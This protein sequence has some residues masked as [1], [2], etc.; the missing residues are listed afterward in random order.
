[1]MSM[2][3]THAQ[4]N[5]TGDWHGTLDVQG[6]MTLRIVFHINETDGKLISTLDSP[7]QS[8]FGL[9]TSETD[10]NAPALTIKMPNLQ[11]EYTGTVNTDFTEMTGTFTQG[12]PMPLTMTRNAVEAKPVLRPQEPKPPFPYYTEDVTYENESA[13]ITLAGTL[14]LPSKDGKYPVVV[15]VSGSGAQ[16]RNEELLGHKPF[17]VIADYLTRHGIG[18]LRYDDRGVGGSTG[19]HSVATSEDFATDAQSAVAYLKTRSEVLPKKIGIAGHSEG[20][21]IAPMCAVRSKDVAFIVLLAGTG[22]DGEEILLTQID[23]INRAND[24]SEEKNKAELAMMGKALGMVKSENDT[25]LLRQ[26][27]NLLFD[28][29]YD[30]L[31]EEDK[32]AAGTKETF[33]K[34]Q[35]ETLTSDWFRFFI[36]YD[37]KATLEKVTCPVLAIN[38]EKDLQVEPK[39]NLGGIE[40]ALKKSGNKHFVVK[41]LPGLNHLFQNCTTGAPSEYFKIEETFDPKALALVSDWILEVVK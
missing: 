31:S 7:D 28:E 12:A 40:A 17:L 2:P 10:F 37:P 22:G 3:F 25:A 35:T 18:V 34:A 39:I 14:T 29:Y 1:M 38:G 26:K 19:D 27:M 8:A 11:A 5:I 6:V 13:G 23:L 9:P 4:K 30:S 20:G 36:K 33:Q 24:M 41:E 32:Q 15:L 16:N 21:M